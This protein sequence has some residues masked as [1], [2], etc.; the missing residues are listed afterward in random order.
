MPTTEVFDFEVADRLEEARA[1]CER[2]LADAPEDVNVLSDAAEFFVPTPDQ[3]TR[4]ENGS[5]AASRSLVE[6][7][8]WRGKHI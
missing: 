4:T 6:H 1:A 8:R 7:R 5:S 2:A 3:R